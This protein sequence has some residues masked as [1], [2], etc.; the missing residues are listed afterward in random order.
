MCSEFQNLKE[1]YCL[2]DAGEDARIILKVQLRELGCRLD[3]A[4]SGGY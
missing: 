3:S 4:G 1:G 2:G